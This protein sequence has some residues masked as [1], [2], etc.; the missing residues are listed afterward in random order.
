M[1]SGISNMCN[2]V[3]HTLGHFLRDK[4]LLTYCCIALSCVA[5]YSYPLL[6]MVFLT[7]KKLV[8]AACHLVIDQVNRVSGTVQSLTSHG[9]AFPPTLTLLRGC[10]EVVEWLWKG[11]GHC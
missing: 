3:T 1:E 10:G 8:L 2:P 7:L 5:Y 6:V 11:C 4:A 9:S